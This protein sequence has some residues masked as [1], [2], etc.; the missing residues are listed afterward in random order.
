MYSNI[1]KAQVRRKRRFALGFGGGG[2]GGRI[3]QEPGYQDSGNFATLNV[4]AWS[5]D[6]WLTTGVLLY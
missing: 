2:E 3:F 1:Q 4:L 5:G 6:F